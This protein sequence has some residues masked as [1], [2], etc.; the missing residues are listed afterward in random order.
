M[1]MKSIQRDDDVPL[2]ITAE[3][4]KLILDNTF[5]DEHLEDLLQQALLDPDPDAET[6]TGPLLVE[7]LINLEVQAK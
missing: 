2:E 7:P 5:L 1:N 4:R 3:E 6:Q